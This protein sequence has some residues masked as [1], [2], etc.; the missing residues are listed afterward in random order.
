MAS[1]KQTGKLV[2]MMLLIMSA[3]LGGRL[4]FLARQHTHKENS[5]LIPRKSAN[6]KATQS[7]RNFG[8]EIANGRR[9]LRALRPDLAELQIENWGL[10][11]VGRV[12]DNTVIIALDT[13]DRLIFK[14]SAHGKVGLDIM[15]A[16]PNGILNPKT[17]TIYQ[18]I[19]AHAEKMKQQQTR[20]G[21]HFG[22]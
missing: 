15:P 8:T 6:N 16:I 7:N 19:K 17:N 4:A 14:K 12:E 9:W 11:T 1:K 13:G 18:E 22:P 21:G 10:K 20:P 3:T 5:P 2:F